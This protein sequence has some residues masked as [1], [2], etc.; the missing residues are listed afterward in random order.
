MSF[1]LRVKL[2]SHFYGDICEWPDVNGRWRKTV[3]DRTKKR[4]SAQRRMPGAESRFL[5]IEPER[6]L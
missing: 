6:R 2:S 3:G 5:L 1:R 4:L